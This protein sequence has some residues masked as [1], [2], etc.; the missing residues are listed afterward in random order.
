MDNI[1]LSTHPRREIRPRL[2]TLPQDPVKLPGTVRTNL[3]PHGFF[4]GQSGEADLATALG[5][6]LLW[7]DVIGHRGGLDAD[8]ND[9]GLSHGQEQLFGLARAILHKERSSIILLDEATSS[10]DYETDKRLQNLLREEFSRH[11]VLAV[12]HRLDTIRDYNLVVVMER[13]RIAEVG[14]PRQLR[15]QEGS[16]FQRLSSG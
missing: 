14:N 13:G 9:L 3:D 8:F 10:V 15:D 11:T 6:V 2:I 5:K 16:A 1:D 12:A 4:N 7:D